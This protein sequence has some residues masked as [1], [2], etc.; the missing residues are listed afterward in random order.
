VRPARRVG[1]LAVGAVLAVL[2]AL[3]VAGCGGRHP[4]PRAGAG[5]GSDHPAEH[6]ARG[7]R[8]PSPAAQIG[9]L[10]RRR[11]RALGD[12][13]A[14]AYAAT[15]TGEQRRRD[16]RAARV[17]AGLGVR[18]V[19]L[20]VRT[21]AVAGARARVRSVSA[22]KVRGVPG[23]FRSERVLRA[24]RT[25]GGW[26]V[27]RVAGR[28]GRAPW[29]VAPVRRLD[30]PHFAILAP[31]GL[32]VAAA[33]L[34]AALAEGYAR[35]A[36]ALPRAPLSRRYLVVVAG[37]APQ[38]RALT[39][40][41]HGVQTLA[42][43]SDTTVREGGPAERVRA[44]L[45]QR[46]LVVWPPF[47]ALDPDARRRVIAHELT[48]LAL[49]RSTSG[50]TPSWLVEGIALYVSGDRRDAEATAVLRG[51]G[52]QAAAERPALSLRRLS[53]PGAIGRLSGPR[54]SGAYAYASAA[55]FA[56]ADAHGRRALLRL[57][58]AFNDPRLRGR[59]GPAL[60]DRALRRTVGESLAAFEAALRARLS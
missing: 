8:P 49:A 6:R 42:A 41:I 14:R 31:R 19:R 13:D 51:G 27:A 18:R 3:A 11:G 43:I 29:E 28:R 38:A 30:E 10:L 32:D 52:P 54:Q 15:A 46:L 22:W 39:Q 48:H 21:A 35:F 37:D 56:L 36:A 60:V 1:L 7:D 17:A 53:R 12:G 55:A 9:A 33:G 25:P 24:V 16:R 26:R 45:A 20:E 47:A 4:A 34:P 58:D 44:V 5:R 40:E 50:R 59:P 23:T 57:Y 2:A